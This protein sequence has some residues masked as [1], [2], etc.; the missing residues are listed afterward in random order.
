MMRTLLAILLVMLLVGCER[1][2]GHYSKGM[3]LLGQDNAAAE[4]Q[5]ALAILEDDNAAM[6]H[7]QLAMLCDRDPALGGVTAWHISEYLKRASGL[8]EKEIQ[9][10][11]QWLRITEKKYAIAISRKLGEDITDETSL[12]LKLLE[13]HA[14][15]Q[16]LWIQELSVENMNLRRQLAD[17]QEK[18]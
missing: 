9:D 8:T 18:K 17:M 12:R 3:S 4:K 5:F 1:H 13:E 7:L 14:V 2:G 6:A 10:A 15:R 16:K 11:E